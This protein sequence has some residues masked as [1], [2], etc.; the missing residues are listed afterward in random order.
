M[1]KITLL[2]FLLISIASISQNSSDYIFEKLTNED[3][4]QKKYELDTTANAVVLMDLGSTV[5]LTKLDELAR[6]KQR[7]ISTTYY[8]KIKFFNSEEFKNQ[9]TIKI[10]LYN[11]T[12]EEETVI[13]IKAVT[14]NNFEKTYVDKENIYEERINDKWREVKFTMPNLKE[15]SI[16]EVEY[17]IESP[18]TFTL[19]SW[20]FQSNIPVKFSQYTASIPGNYVFNRKLNGTLKL[21]TNSSTVKKNCFVVS[22]FERAAN[23]EVIT[24]AMENIPAFKEEKEFM[25]S[26]N[27]FIS[28]I[29]F[30]LADYQRING[31]KMKYTTTWEAVDK[32]FK[33]DKDIGGQLKQTKLLDNIVPAEINSL[34]TDLEKAKAVYS[35]IQSYYTWNEKYGLFS[36]INIKNAIE[37]KSGNVGEINISLINALKSVGLNAELVLISTRKNGFPTKLHPV[38][39]D[40]NYMLARITIHNKSYLLDATNKL[41]PF[42]LLPYKCLNGYGRVMD[43]ENSSYWTAIIPENNS[44]NQISVSLKL[45]DDGTFHGKLRKVNFGYDALSRRTTIL[46]KSDDAIIAKF[47]DSFNN[48]EV[49]GYK[50]ENKLDIN[51]PLIETF[52]ISLDNS[53]NKTVQY[54]NPFFAEQFKENPFKQENRLYPVDFGYTRKYIV[55]LSLEIPENYSIES[56][57]DKKSFALP[58]N[59]GNFSLSLNTNSSTKITLYSSIKINKP[60]FYNS[61]YQLLKELFKEI[62][63]SQK[64]PIVLKKN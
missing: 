15:G 46:N 34:T 60:V 11:T 14:H 32:K 54:F 8:T 41:T 31:Y 36:E 2:T 64:T 19:P 21:K 63:N 47:E 44:K 35:F 27:N 53:E 45:Y 59:G 20:V 42:G 13:N 18:F 51:Q 57:P 29:K 4:I 55:N 28:K 12:L 3:L 26:K 37:N 50:I 5:F 56:F 49:L 40:F 58:E 61:E 38:I 7:I 25:T 16:I 1:K 6:E 62:I 17:T 10:R 52:E 24:Y 22:E 30:E 43:F 23:C 33:K 9:G 48:L 39:S